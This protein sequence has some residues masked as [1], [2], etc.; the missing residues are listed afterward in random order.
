MSIPTYTPGYPPDGSSL[1]QTKSV[2]RN[3]L[4]GT[5]QTLGIDHVNN[6]GQPGGKPAGYHTVIHSVPQGSNPAPVAGYGQL[7]SKTINSFTTD[8]ALFWE[9]GAGL[10]QQLTVNLTPSPAANG[11]TFLPGGLI[12]QWGKINSTASSFQTLTFAT[13]NIAFPNNCF[14]IWT[15]VYGNSGTPATSTGNVEIRQSTLTRTTFQW[16]F[17]TS[18]SQYTGFY[19]WALGN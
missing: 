11:Y 15:Q 13:S 6:N 3:N 16:A 9:T 8:Q 10:I 14:G 19:W 7:F 2:I 5:F 1:G 18:S 17:V 4:D 12:L